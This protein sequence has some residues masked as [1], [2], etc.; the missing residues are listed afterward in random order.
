MSNQLNK[1]DQ[2]TS[3]ATTNITKIDNMVV[4]HVESAMSDLE[5]D[6]MELDSIMTVLK[7]RMIESTE[8]S[9]PISLARFAEIKLASRRQKNE[10]LKT[11]IA[12]KT[13]EQITKKRSSDASSSVQDILAGVGLGAAMTAGAKLNISGTGSPVEVERTD[14]IDA[15][16]EVEP[17]ETT[18]QTS[19]DSILKGFNN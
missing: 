9:F 6:I 12:Y 8:A 7:D 5:T 13:G 3:V 14:V 17:G 4:D 1:R 16:I 2:N 18:A 10:L 11:L 19:V 15:E